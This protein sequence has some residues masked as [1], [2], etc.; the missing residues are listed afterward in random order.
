MVA[1]SCPLL[2]SLAAFL[3]ALESAKILAELPLHYCLLMVHE[4]VLGP[5]AP[6]MGARLDQ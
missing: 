2:A 1:L 4:G 3:L 5:T 6:G